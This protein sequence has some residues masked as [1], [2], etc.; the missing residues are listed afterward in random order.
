MLCYVMLCYVWSQ[1]EV[2]KT[3]EGSIKR[4]LR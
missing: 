4:E 1:S 2:V 3:V